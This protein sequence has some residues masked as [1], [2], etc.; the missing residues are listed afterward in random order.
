MESIRSGQNLDSAK[1]SHWG[2]RSGIREINV[3]SDCA[4]FPFFY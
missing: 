1:I 3:V 2:H 4:R